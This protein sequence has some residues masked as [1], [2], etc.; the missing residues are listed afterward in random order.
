MV[1]TSESISKPILQP[2]PVAP[3]IVEAAG[4]IIKSLPP[5]SRLPHFI[6]LFSVTVTRPASQEDFACNITGNKVSVMLAE[7]PPNDNLYPF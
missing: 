5:G 7:P 1:N 6:F 4:E 2:I 3:V